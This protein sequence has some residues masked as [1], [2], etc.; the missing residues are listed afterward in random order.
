[1]DYRKGFSKVLLRSAKD[2]LRQELRELPSLMIQCPCC[3]TRTVLWNDNDDVP[4]RVMAHRLCVRCSLISEDQLESSSEN[5][6]GVLNQQL[7]ESNQKKGRPEDSPFLDCMCP[8]EWS[9]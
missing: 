9:R 6:A 7:L 3:G 5:L 2:C 4:G 1:M 8:R